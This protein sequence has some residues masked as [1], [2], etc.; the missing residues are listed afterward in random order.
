MPLL[1]NRQRHKRCQMKWKCIKCRMQKMLDTAPREEEEDTTPEVDSSEALR[2]FTSINLIGNN[3]TMASLSTNHQ[4]HNCRKQRRSITS[5]ICQH[6]LVLK[7]D[8]WIA[9]KICRRVTHQPKR[10]QSTELH[11]LK[12]QRSYTCNSLHHQLCT[13][14]SMWRQFTTEWLKCLLHQCD[15]LQS[16][17]KMSTSITP[18]KVTITMSITIYNS[19]Q[20]IMDLKTC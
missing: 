12:C 19:I 11:C 8:P 14:V 4:C 15:Q 6:M 17:S 18:W 7:R 1:L 13:K 5:T 3:M 10:H 20:K 9:S 16:Q 2:V